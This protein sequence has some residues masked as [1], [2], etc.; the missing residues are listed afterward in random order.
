MGFAQEQRSATPVFV[1]ELAVSPA[2][3][4]AATPHYPR[5]AITVVELSP[6]YLDSPKAIISRTGSQ[7]AIWTK[8]NWQSGRFETCTVTPRPPASARSVILSDPAENGRRRWPVRGTTSIKRVGGSQANVQVGVSPSIVPPTVYQ[9]ALSTVAG[10][11][12]GR[13]YCPRDQPVLP[14]ADELVDATLPHLPVVIADM[15]RFQRLTGCR[16]GEV[17]QLRPCDVDRS[18]EMW[19]YRTG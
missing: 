3:P 10:L 14:V 6:A 8:S 11:R 18:G 7:P 12:M 9:A 13:T 1:A 2:A 17:C 16:P 4:D 5:V 15:V 19:E